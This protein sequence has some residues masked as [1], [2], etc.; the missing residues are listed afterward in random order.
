MRSLVGISPAYYYNEGYDV[1]FSSRNHCG[2]VYKAQ[3]V[4]L[5]SLDVLASAPRHGGIFDLAIATG[6][7]CSPPQD[8]CTTQEFILIAN[9][10]LQEKDFDLWHRRACHP[11]WESIKWRQKKTHGLKLSGDCPSDHVC[12]SCISAKMHR[13]PHSQHDK[14]A[15]DDGLLYVD[16]TFPKD[17]LISIGGAKAFIGFTHNYSGYQWGF[18]IKSKADT[19]HYISQ[20]IQFVERVTGIKVK[21]IRL[22]QGG[23]NIKGELQLLLNSHGISMEYTNTDDHQQL[24]M[25]ERSFRTS[26]ER[27]RTMLHTAANGDPVLREQLK[28]LY[29]DVGIMIITRI[30]LS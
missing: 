25:Q 29:V 5:S 15:S 17:D 9:S 14:V 26:W 30:K 7:N 27:V 20:S 8:L 12:D 19:M 11:T 18:G 16:I 6:Y 22:D 21:C 3:E 10:Y 4:N 1:L 23:E 13:M 24:G 2:Y 28:R